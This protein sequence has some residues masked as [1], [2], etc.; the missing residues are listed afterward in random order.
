MSFFYLSPLPARVSIISEPRKPKK[1]ENAWNNVV[2]SDAAQS[3]LVFHL[4]E[5]EE[6]VCSCLW[7]M[8]LYQ[9]AFNNIRLHSWFHIYAHPFL[10]TLTFF[11]FWWGGFFFA[12][13]RSDIGLQW[14]FILWSLIYPPTFFLK[15]IF[16]IYNLFLHRNKIIDRLWFS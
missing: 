8:R 6:S 9:D 2:Q 1:T 14:L 4:S 5:R 10:T 11:F 3:S 12:L 15:Y 13:H 7:N 16:F